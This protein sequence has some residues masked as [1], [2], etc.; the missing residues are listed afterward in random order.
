MTDAILHQVQQVV[1][2]IPLT[3]ISQGAEALV[4]STD[5]HPY[6]PEAN[7]RYIVKYR[8]RKPYRHAKIDSMI[9]KLRTVGEAKFMAKLTKLGV[10]APGLILLDAANGI[11]WMEYVGTVLPDGSVSSAKNYLWL[12]EKSGDKDS[13]VSTEV[14]QILRATGEAIGKL[15]M[16]DMIHGDLTTSNLIL[17]DDDAYLIDFGLS[18]YSL[19]PED[20]AV[21]LYVMERAVVSTHSDYA[22][23]Y[24]MWLL[25]GYQTA[26]EK[27]ASVGGRKKLQE[28]MRKLEDV[29]MRGRKRSMLG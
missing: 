28:T 20:K 8:P 9:T 7:S 10:R 16:N 17:Q 23:Q 4:F 1:P 25:Q 27:M 18:S 19:L 13:C 12:L 26:H 22:D 5:V 29:R 21:D 14:E 24:N 11:I 15:H 6:S 2:H 3:V